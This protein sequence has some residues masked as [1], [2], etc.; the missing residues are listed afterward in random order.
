MTLGKMACTD[1]LTGH[2]QTVPIGNGS[3]TNVENVLQCWR[4]GGFLSATYGATCPVADRPASTGDSLFWQFPCRT[5]AS[6]WSAHEALQGAR[7]LGDEWHVYLG[8]PWA[9]WIDKARKQ[10]WGS[11]GW[12]QAEHQWRRVGA[13]LA[14][15]RTALAHLGLGLRVHTVC[16]HVYWRD[17]LPRW[18]EELGVT[19][20]WLSHCP[21]DE[22]LPAGPRLH[23]WRLFAVNVE[24]PS[25]SAG[26]EPDR[27]CSRRS[28]LASFIGAH[29]N[30]YLSDIRLRLRALATSP[31]ILVEV[32][33]RWHFEEIVYEHQVQSLRPAPV[34]DTVA[35]RRYNQV[36]SD[37]VFSLCPPG[38]GANT[39]RLWESLASGSI[40]VL[41]DPMPQLPRGGTLPPFD[42]DDALVRVHDAELPRLIDRLRQ[43]PQAERRRR[44]MRGRELFALASS[45]TCF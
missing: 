17:L 39:L 27:D 38:A 1:H 10:S 24:D 41:F 20:L 40:P 29:A 14:G 7:L 34:D 36:L 8:L 6:A 15:I 2:R 28:L 45:Q 16:Q 43:M 30:H 32:T 25:R 12:A 21:T 22:S 37:S 18:S 44:Q 23:P 35:I 3:R 42:W 26:L 4:Q 31:D 13:R 5:E 9:T 33:D 11:N 19:D